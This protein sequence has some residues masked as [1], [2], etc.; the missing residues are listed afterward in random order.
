[1]PRRAD[2]KKV[3]VIGSGPI[4]IGQAAE[5]DYSGSQACQA[6][7][8]E[9]VKVVLVNSNPATIQTDLETAD[10]VYIEP[11]NAETLKKIIEKEK[12]DGFIAT[13]SGQT[14]LNLAVELRDFLKEKSV[15]VLGTSIETIELA[16]DREK[17][18]DLMLKIGE[19]VPASLRVKNLDELKKAVGKISLPVILRPDFNL[20]GM[21]TMIVEKESEIEEKGD[22][23]FASSGSGELLVE[24]SVA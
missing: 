12:P 21:G 19:H 18:R 13:M 16:E 14:G 3:L 17:F 10:V 4:T 11:L 24:K 8:E 1:M 2:I 6:L 5:F 20:G 23:C 9:G 7:R 22:S 15:R